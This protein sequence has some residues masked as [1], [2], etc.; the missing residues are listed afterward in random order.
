MAG[1]LC[2]PSR[3]LPSPV[4]GC[5][6]FCRSISG[7][8]WTGCRTR[9]RSACARSRVWGNQ[10]L[11]MEPSLSRMERR[12][13]LPIFPSWPAAGGKR[14]SPPKRPERR[15]TRRR[16]RTSARMTSSSQWRPLR[17]FTGPD[18]IYCWTPGYPETCSR[19]VRL[20][21]YKLFSYLVAL[22]GYIFYQ[23]ETLKQR[24]CFFVI[25]L[26]NGGHCLNASNHHAI[27]YDTFSY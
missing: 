15:Q 5:C 7:L 24:G 2:S 21:L 14:I 27:L 3:G 1:K 6:C 9:V 8:R 25:L 23:P 18:W 12:D 4:W 16:L 19:Y 17:S 11:M 26:I 20:L 22:C 10:R 13:S